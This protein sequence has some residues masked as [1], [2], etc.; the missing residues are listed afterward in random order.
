MRGFGSWEAY[1]MDNENAQVFARYV[2]VF[3]LSVLLEP[4]KP[5]IGV[6]NLEQRRRASAV[7]SI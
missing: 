7:I 2:L 6:L 4:W 3:P 1:N 5:S